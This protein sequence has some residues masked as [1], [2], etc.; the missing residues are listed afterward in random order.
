MSAPPRCMPPPGSP[1]FLAARERHGLEKTEQGEGRAGNECCLR[2]GR[3]R[4]R[5]RHRSGGVMTSRAPCPHA[6]QGFRRPAAPCRIVGCDVDQ[7]IGVDEY[8]GCH[9]SP[10]VS[11]MIS[12]VVRPACALPRRRAMALATGEGPAGRVRR[13]TPSSPSANSTS[14]PGGSR[15]PRGFPVEW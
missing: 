9:S 3:R 4:P 15:R 7:D 13:T 10:R 6:L 14:V 8:R 12:S 11:A 1:S 5:P 2:S